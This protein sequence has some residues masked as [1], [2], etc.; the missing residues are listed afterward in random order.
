MLLKTSAL[1]LFAA[2]SIPV[3]PSL[4]AEQVL[5]SSIP[6]L[7]VAPDGNVYYNIHHPCTGVACSLVLDKFHYQKE[8]G[9]VM[10]AV[11][12]AVVTPSAPITDVGFGIWADNNGSPGTVLFSEGV[13]PPLI[14]TTETQFGTTIVRMPFL[15]PFDLQ[16]GDYWMSLFSEGGIPGYSGGSGDLLYNESAP[17]PYDFVH[18]GDSAAFAILGG[19]TPIP[20]CST[21]AMIVAG[22][23]GIGLMARARRKAVAVA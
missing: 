7:N 10:F 18:T 14:S 21:W 9:I 17:Y 15:E 12:E 3:A 1:A 23:A 11:Q 22:F 20:E 16:T 2:L 4:A 6:D 19:P 5:F 8:P 13:G